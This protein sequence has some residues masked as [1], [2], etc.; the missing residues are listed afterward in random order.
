MSSRALADGVRRVIFE[1]NMRAQM[2]RAMATVPHDTRSPGVVA[3]A[4]ADLAAQKRE[5]EGEEEAG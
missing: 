1:A 4:D 2:E 5:S 3:K